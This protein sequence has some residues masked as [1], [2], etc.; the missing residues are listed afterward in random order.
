MRFVL[1]ALVLVLMPVGVMA[2]PVDIATETV[3]EGAARVEFVWAGKS[4][5]LRF[6]RGDEAVT[7]RMGA[8]A[9]PVKE[10]RIFA[11]F[12]RE[13]A[14]GAATHPDAEWGFAKSGLIATMGRHTVGSCDAF[15]TTKGGRVFVSW[16]YNRACFGDAGCNTDTVTLGGTPGFF[17]KAATK[18]DEAV[19][20]KPRTAP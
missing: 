6:Q 5:R 13:V 20:R 3:S 18:M 4:L 9:P 12:V 2:E 1:F 17:L 15:A 8:G 16:I 14:E 11:G 10:L 7:C 19:A